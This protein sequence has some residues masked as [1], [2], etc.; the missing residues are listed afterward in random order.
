MQYLWDTKLTGA[1]TERVKSILR[2]GLPP[3]RYGRTTVQKTLLISKVVFAVTN[4]APVENERVVDTWAK[5][6]GHVLWATRSGDER[7]AAHLD[8]GAPPSLIPHDVIVQDHGEGGQ[9]ALHVPCFTDSLRATW[10]TRLLDPA[11]QP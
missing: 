11:P 8:R 2:A 10:I 9:R 7:E 3:T 4:Q 6:M 1:I 5:Q